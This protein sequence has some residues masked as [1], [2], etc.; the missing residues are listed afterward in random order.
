MSW[1]SY[2]DTGLLGTRRVTPA[3]IFGLDGSQWVSAEGFTLAAGEVTA[4]VSPFADPTAAFTSGITV[5]GVN[6]LCTRADDRSIYGEH[7]SGGVVAVKTVRTVIITVYDENARSDEVA[8]IVEG[9]AD[10][11]IGVG[12]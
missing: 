7:G 2:A 1:Q 5:K 4:L 9:L 3:G 6:Y 11:L 10:S 12:S 8:R